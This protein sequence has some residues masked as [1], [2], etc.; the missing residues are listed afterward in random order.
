MTILDEP[1]KDFADIV[2]DVQEC[3]DRGKGLEQLATTGLTSLLGIRNFGYMMFDVTEKAKTDAA[4]ARNAF[5]EKTLVLQNLL[6]ESGYYRKEIQEARDYKSAVSKSDL[7][8]MVY[9][10]FM[11]AASADFITGL[12]SAS[13]DYDHQLMLRRLEH[14]LQSRKQARKQLSELKARR[15]ALH[16]NLSQK[17]K[18][19]TDL[20]KHAAHI[21]SATQNVRKLFS[22]PDAS[23]AQGQQEMA[24]LLPL[25]LYFIFSQATA[26]LDTLSTSVRP[27]VVGSKDEAE[28]ELAGITKMSTQPARKRQKR[29]VS[30]G[31]ALESDLYQVYTLPHK[32][33]LLHVMHR[34]RCIEASRSC[35]PCNLC[36]C[37]LCIASARLYAEY[38]PACFVLRM[39][40]N[41]AQF[42]AWSLAYGQVRL[43]HCR[44]SLCQSSFT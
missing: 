37:Y 13:E 36:Y 22:I 44:L 38:R 11:Q 16:T 10:D 31:S 25:P 12:D 41:S 40:L 30:M 27:E 18:A 2:Q 34:C 29:C 9:E 8:L 6:Y 4:R 39:L 20:Q 19:L 17:R 5:D 14:E 33:L 3:T 24:Q 43:H 23:A 35:C 26:I 15:D 21:T 28:A 1:C 42:S 7:E 32:S